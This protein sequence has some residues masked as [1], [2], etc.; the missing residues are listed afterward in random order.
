M[1][2][3]EKYIIII[4]IIC[5]FFSN[6]SLTDKEKKKT[7]LIRADLELLKTM[8]EKHK[9]VTTN[10][11]LP[12]AGPVTMTKTKDSVKIATI[13]GVNFYVQKVGADISGDIICPAWSAIAVTRND[14]AFF[15]HKEKAVQ[16]YL[17]QEENDEASDDSLSC[18]LLLSRSCPTSRDDQTKHLK[19]VTIDLVSRN[20]AAFFFWWDMKFSAVKCVVLLVVR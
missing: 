15:V 19:H 1:F 16:L 10:L 7:D 13:M 14:Q 8:I 18:N 2:I 11:F 20:L 4:I 6:C 3:F 17:H 5:F 9:N 12:F